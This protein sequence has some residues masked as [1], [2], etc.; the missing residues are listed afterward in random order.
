MVL[1]AEPRRQIFIEKDP[2]LTCSRTRN[3]A[4][5]GTTAE[6]LWVHAQEGRSLGEIER[7]HGIVLRQAGVQSYAGALYAGF[8]L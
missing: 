5:E 4:Y 2:R 6:C 3:L 7:S 8:R 1:R